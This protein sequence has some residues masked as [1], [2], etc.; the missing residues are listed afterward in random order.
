LGGGTQGR[1]ESALRKGI[2]MALCKKASRPVRCGRAL[3]TGACV[4]A[5]AGH[6]L[7]C[8]TM[9]LG[10]AGRGVVAYSY[11]QTLTGAG[12]VVV[13][14]VGVLRTSIMEAPQATWRAAHA[15]ISFN[16]FGP[17][18]PTA[19][20]NDAGLVVTLMWNDAADFGATPDRPRLNE[21]EF[22]QYLLDTAAT[23]DGALAALDEVRID[24]MIPIQFFLS[25]RSGAA[26]TLTYLAGKPVVNRGTT[27]PVPVLTNVNYEILREVLSDQEV[28]RDRA[29]PGQEGSLARFLLGAAAVRAQSGGTDVNA[30]FAAL[31]DVRVPATQWQI[32]FDPAA[33]VAT[34][35]MAGEETARALRLAELDVSCTT[36]PLAVQVD[37]ASRSLRP[38]DLETTELVLAE[39]FGSFP[40]FQAF[41]P[42]FPA[43]VAAAQLTGPLCPEE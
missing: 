30:A 16:Q 5:A 26:A 13:N 6:A 9:A 8:T 31:E 29:A 7:A 1:I 18:M 42:E 24:G 32:V 19:G 39:A 12:M 3:A 40:Q 38:V 15:S 23:V 25:D 27:L 22:I 41:G 35:R 20:V 43:A 21:L 4:L 34:W 36:A 2:T 33:G 10:P 14:P 28:V 37:D 11:D 17:G